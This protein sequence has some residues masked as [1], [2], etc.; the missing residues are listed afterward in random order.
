MYRNVTTGF[1]KIVPNFVPSTPN[2]QLL[3]QGLFGLLFLQVPRSMTRVLSLQLLFDDT[4]SQQRKCK[5]IANVSLV[6]DEHAQPINADAKSSGRRKPSPESFYKI[7]V[8]FRCLQIALLPCLRIKEK[9][10]D[11]NACVTKSRI[12]YQSLQFESPSLLIRIVQFRVGIGILAS[13]NK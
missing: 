6:C 10:S 13:P 4:R 11:R 1:Q 7:V 12:P 9:A 2:R 5:D 3:K 8:C